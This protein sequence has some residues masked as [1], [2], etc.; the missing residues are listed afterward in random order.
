MAQ[1]ARGAGLAA[2]LALAGCGAGSH[3]GTTEAPPAQ[4]VEVITGEARQ[5]KH[6][7]TA[8]VEGGFTVSTQP[9]TP[10]K[11]K[12]AI[13]RPPRLQR[14]LEKDGDTVSTT[15][16]SE[17]ES[18][19]EDDLAAR[20]LD[21]G[22]GILPRSANPY[23]LA[24]GYRNGQGEASIAVYATTNGARTAIRN[25]NMRLETP[26]RNGTRAGG[27]GEAQATDNVAWIAWTDPVKTSRQL[28]ECS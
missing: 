7:S 1:I 16:V 4:T 14:C 24:R 2:L 21:F 19:Y 26:E 15:A 17:Q 28:A 25:A 6:S 22:N 5:G 11:P 8:E 12:E 13:I 9:T 20:E 27:V 10:E 3:K 18:K 23:L